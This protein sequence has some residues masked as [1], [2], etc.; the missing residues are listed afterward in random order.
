MSKSPRADSIGARASRFWRPS[1]SF[2][3]KH[4]LCKAR[5]RA[6]K[7]NSSS[8]Q[9]VPIKIATNKKTRKFGTF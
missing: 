5:R 4:L 2:V 7:E 1:K 3:G 8:R 9:S 6:E